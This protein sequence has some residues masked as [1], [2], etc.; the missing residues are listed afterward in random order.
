MRVSTLISILPALVA[1]GA[2]AP[3]S[4]EGILYNSVICLKLT[5]CLDGAALV[6][7][8]A[9]ADTA[10]AYPQGKRA[11]ADIAASFPISKRADADTASAYPQ[12]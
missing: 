10:S 6:D 12:G 2:A 4:G 3:I 7:P 5:Q 8:R 11:D 9:D 1:L